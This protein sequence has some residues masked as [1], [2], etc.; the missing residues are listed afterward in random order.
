MLSVLTKSV[1]LRDRACR[2]ILLVMIANVD[3]RRFVLHFLP[4]VVVISS[5]QICAC[6]R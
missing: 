1:I 5:L 3:R 6:N 2:Y 4:A